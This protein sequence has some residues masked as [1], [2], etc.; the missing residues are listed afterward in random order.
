MSPKESA[1]FIIASLAGAKLS[2]IDEAAGPSPDLARIVVAVGHEK[3]LLRDRRQIGRAADI[4]T[5]WNARAIWRRAI[6][7]DLA[8]GGTSRFVR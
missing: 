4:D 1:R 5:G 7:N 6:Q 8:L 2:N 3:A